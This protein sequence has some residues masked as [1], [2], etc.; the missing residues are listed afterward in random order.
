M[1]TILVTGASSG[2]GKACALLLAAKGY[3]VLASV[4]RAEDG[5]ALREQASGNVSS[6]LLDVTD[7]SSIERAAAE[8]GQ[9]V[10]AAGLSGLVNNAGIGQA[11]P[12]EYFPLEDVRRQL[13][14]NVLGP[15]AVTQAFL[16]LIRRAQ[17]RIVN[18]GS[19]GD[20]ITMPFGGPL[21]ASKRA[22]AALTEALRLELRPWGIHV[23]L[24]EP[25]SISTPAVEKVAA[26][27]ERL[28]ARLPRE[29]AAR[30]GALFRSFLDR[31]MKRER[32]GSAPDVVAAT[33][34]RALTE[35]R[36]RT[37]YLVGKDSQLLS[38]L[39]YLPDRALDSLRLRIFGLP[40]AFGA[41]AGRGHAAR[42]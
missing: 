18:I 2:I 8:A 10:G 13:E 28:L 41:L 11:G 16:P 17:G 29:G 32:A 1:G 9:R 5:E 19:I 27:G 40:T 26:D 21:C 38:R 30:Y 22:V 25:G 24:V 33:V 12:L 3:A 39:A 36:P 34:L 31:G 6:L 15:L 7:G 35:P 23:A 4:R 42:T 20:R 14:V 37:R